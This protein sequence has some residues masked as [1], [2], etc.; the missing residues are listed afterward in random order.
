VKIG[1]R[2]AVLF[3]FGGLKMPKIVIHLNDEE[4]TLLRK[5]AAKTIR[6]PIAQAY[7]I[8]INELKRQDELIKEDEPDER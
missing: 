4:L 1:L 3:F 8:L 5:V 2:K 7:V 6:D